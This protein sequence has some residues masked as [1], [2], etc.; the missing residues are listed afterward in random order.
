MSVRNEEDIF[1]EQ[2]ALVQERANSLYQ[3]AKECPSRQPQLLLECLENLQ[4]ALEELHV[5]ES[6]LHH[7]NEQLAIAHQDLQAERRRYQELFEF[8]PDAYLITDLQGTVQEANQAA[9]ELFQINPSRLI[10][11]PLVNFVQ[12]EHRRPFRNTLNQLPTI[13]R[14]Q[15]WELSLLGRNQTHVEAALTVQTARNEAGEAIALRWL[16]RDITARKR[17]EEQ[18]RQLQLQNLQLIEADRLK[19]QFMATMS[20]ELRT[21][22]NAILGFSDLLLR[23]F[24]NQYD[25]QQINMIERIFNNGRHLLSLI[26]E[27]LDFSKLKGHRLD[28]RLEAF[29]LAELATSV[30]EEMESLTEQ[31]NLELR[32]E[33]AELSILVVNDRMRLRQILINLLS[34]AIKF[35]EQGSVCLEIALV[36]DDQV[37]IIVRDTGIGIEPADQAS[38][39]KEFRQLNQTTTRRHS[40]TGLG[41]SITDALVQLM[42]GSIVVDSKVGVGSIFRV[43][44]PRWVV[45]S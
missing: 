35:T 17:A 2:I 22:M 3:S 9:G 21:P 11:K 30:V 15:E 14:V 6:E 38:I 40:G 45:A 5:A 24:H 42:Q 7:Q 28:L 36:A 34:N 39:F 31:K 32:L 37:A 44:L 19:T 41:L 12:E 25:A 4:V 1:A 29:D 33:L 20:H 43:N 10:G 18:M 8:A 16:I 23:R 27:I 13:H 26:E